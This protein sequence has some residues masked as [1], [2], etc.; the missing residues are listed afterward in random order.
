MENCS[1]PADAGLIQCG[2]GIYVRSAVEEQS[3]RCNVAVFR[4]HMQKRSPLKQEETSTGLAAIEFREAFI[5]KPGISVNHLRQAIEPTAEQLH[6]SRRVVL[7]RATSLEKDVDAGA[8]SLCGARVTRNEVV[9][10][11][12]RI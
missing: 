11:R 2:A 4:S 1:L 10:G 7:G 8:Q 12:A 5:H 6:H 3:N 9:E